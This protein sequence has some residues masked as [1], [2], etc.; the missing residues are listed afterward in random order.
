M[1]FR[2]C[3]GGLEIGGITFQIQPL[4]V[5]TEL[6][7]QN[8]WCFECGKGYSLFFFSSANDHLCKS[9]L[10][11]FLLSCFYNISDVQRAGGKSNPV[12]NELCSLQP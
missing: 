1:L 9:Q 5:C 2:V 12:Q 6:F 8:D 3:F 4:L 11:F 10:V 7:M